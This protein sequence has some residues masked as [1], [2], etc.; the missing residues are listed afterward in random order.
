VPATLVARDLTVSF[1]DHLVL[2]GV[3]LTVAPGARVGVVAPNGVGKT[4]V[5]RA[6]AGLQTIDGGSVT[7]VPPT[8]SVGYLPQEA[9]RRPGETV[10]AF[11]G[12]RTGVQ[13]ASEELDDATHALAG[14]DGGD[15]RY[16]AAL[17]RWMAL[18]G[19]D[20]DSRIGPLW[21]D[22]GLGPELLD[23]DTTTLSGG[24]A[25]RASMAGVLLSSF[26]VFL[27][28]EPTNDLD[29]DGLDRLER[30][31]DTLAVGAVIV[32]HDRA[33]LERTITSVL[34]IDEHDHT[35]SVFEGGWHAYLDERA[36]VR[37]HAEEDFEEYRTRRRELEDR[38]R[39][40]RQWAVQGVKS[41]KKPRDN[42]K[43]QRGF[44]VNR[45]E[46][47]AAKVRITEKALE[48]LAAVEK[49]W[50]GWDLRF[51]VASAQRSGDVVARIAGAVVE[52]GAFRLGPVD[53][54]IS[55]GDRVA[56]LGPNGSGKSTLLA[57]M[58][59]RI[60]LVSG[61]RWLGPSV[62]VGEVDQARSR[63][64]GPDT[65]LAAFSAE[66]GIVVQAEARSLLAK[67]GLGADDVMRPAGS[68]TPGERTRATLAVLMARGVNCLVLDEPTNHLDVQAIEQLERALDSY[69]GTLILVTHDRRLLE[70]VRIDRTITLA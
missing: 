18:G 52:R 2:D 53:L 44:F 42:D 46:K 35:A 16:A 47:Q 6:L 32:S 11:L 12:R 22:L 70:A 5:L 15:L 63:L 58:L 25:A 66:S 64:E 59:G 30:F 8:A 28:D 21:A 38:A 60:P 14:G 33:F 26:D 9:E 40:Q 36:T 24:Q 10:R 61:E 45:T 49:P 65:L 34:E 50:E 69:D 41:A 23:Q 62:I 55:W 57:A 13:T 67:F 39:S 51:S 54:R 68:L 3:N 1:G 43:A 7:R 20:L 19:A 27:L 37:R 29:F 56:L 4:T 48:R 31:L 17:E